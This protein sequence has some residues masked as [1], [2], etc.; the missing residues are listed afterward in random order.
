MA[1]TLLDADTFKRPWSMEPF[2]RRRVGEVCLRTLT[3]PAF[4]LL[5]R[6]QGIADVSQ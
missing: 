1:K 6:L 2:A 4:R 5:M 3:E